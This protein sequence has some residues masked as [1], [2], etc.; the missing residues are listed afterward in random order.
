MRTAL[1]LVVIAL[2]GAFVALR[3]EVT[4]DIGDFMPTGHDRE[5]AR[6]AQAVAKGPISR[7]IVI[8]IEA[9]DAEAAVEASRIFE[10]EVRG[11]EALLE[12]FAYFEP[13]PP[14]DLDRALWELYHPRRLSFV[15]RTRQE[16]EALVSDE[17][18]AAA[19]G[20]VQRRLASPLSTLVTRAAPEDPFLA[21]PRLFERVQQGGAGGNVAVID[22]RFVAG[23]RWAVIFVGTEAPALDAEAQRGVIDGLRAAHERLGER[24]PV[25]AFESSGLAKCCRW[26]ASCCCASSCCDRLGSRCSPRSRSGARCWPRPRPR[27]CCTAACTG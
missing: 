1:A 22:G 12:Q 14:Q 15:A 4:T 25:G 17:G 24:M 7:S 13:G 19:A 21:F 26:S 9:D 2:L 16:A 23:E 3:F 6:I 5:L 27:C 18:L 20:D 8:T 11:D 10:E